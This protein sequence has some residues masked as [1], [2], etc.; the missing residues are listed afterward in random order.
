M[1]LPTYKFG[2]DGRCFTMVSTTNTSSCQ[3]LL[4]STSQW[5]TADQIDFLFSCHL[6]MLLVS[7]AAMLPALSKKNWLCA[8][9]PRPATARAA[10]A[11]P[12]QAEDHSPSITNLPP[13]GIHIG[14][15]TVKVD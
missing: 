7:S 15:P 13:C 4:F 3:P 9:N 5:H 8:Q 10:A 12:D 2:D 11:N 14:T 6:L 1:I